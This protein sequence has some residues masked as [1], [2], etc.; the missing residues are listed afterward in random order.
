[1]TDH[2]LEKWAAMVVMG[3]A[4]FTQENGIEG[5]LIP[6]LPNRKGIYKEEWRP[7][8]DLNQCFMVV[9]RMRELGREIK[10]VTGLRQQKRIW[11]CQIWSTMDNEVEEY[12]QNPAKAIIKAAYAALEGGKDL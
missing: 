2:E 10:L 3:Y 4:P 11:L 8:T 1:M 12:G 9:E 6:N 7:L 5:Y